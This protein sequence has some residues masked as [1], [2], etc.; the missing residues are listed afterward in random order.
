M[1]TRAITFVA[2]AAAL[3]AVAGEARANGGLVSSPQGA[4]S[5]AE[6]EVAV[7]SS[8]GRT[9]RWAR[10]RV[11][12]AAGA[13]VW[14]L[15][16]RPGGM[17]DLAS[18][19]WM[20]ALQASTAPRVLQPAFSAPCSVKGGID[21]VGRTEHVATRAPDDVAI[22]TDVASLATALRDWGIALPTN[23]RN[24]VETT[25]TDGS[26]LAL[27]LFS[28]TSNDTTTRTVRVVDDAPAALPL[29]LTSGASAGVAVT[30][31]V[32]GDAR[33]ELGAL[34]A[35]S[36]D[37][38]TIGW[39]AD[40]TST[41]RDA[42]AAAL[43]AS[44]NAWLLESAGASPLFRIQ[45]IPGATIPA[46]TDSYF[47]RAGAYGDASA[48]ATSCAVSAHGASTTTR[49]VAAACPVGALARVAGPGGVPVCIESTAIAQLSPD[50][51][52]CGNRADDL[53]H[54]F[55]LRVPSD[56]WVTRAAGFVP[57][58]V[59]GQDIAIAP[60]GGAT[61]DPVVQASKYD[62]V[63]SSATPGH[64]SGGPTGGGSGGGG[65]SGDPTGGQG[66]VVGVNEDPGTSD[67]AA[68]AGDTCSGFA[69]DGCGGDTSTSSTSSSSDSSCG[70][71]SSGGSSESSGSGCG[72]SSSSS[73]SSNS[74]CGSSSSSSSSSN[75]TSTRRSTRSPFSR[76]AIGALALVALLRRASR[77]RR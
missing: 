43:G 19:A 64:G 62:V 27:L 48:D 12:G 52:R 45:T 46:I 74:G 11:R 4:A 36:L 77:K 73:E 21:V 22:A 18:D 57:A 66:A 40:G 5:I 16:V 72:G 59:Y 53:A 76:Y 67:A 56:T 68:I 9:T 50:P 63:C 30:A 54:A 1:G 38:A 34:P 26:H 42:R 71:S 61:K 6:V 2:A 69:G 35:L 25:F 65:G 20:E 17:L 44:P 8:P 55:S 7:A 33:A 37:P 13:F 70:G 75:C 39:R 29:L 28:P 58:G 32:I 60:G 24:N 49:V 23:L 51:F 47:A 41:W 3:L 31:F 15:P 14:L 10:L